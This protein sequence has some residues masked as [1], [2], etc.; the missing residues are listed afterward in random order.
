MVVLL[1]VVLALVVPQEAE[2]ETGSCPTL[3]LAKTETETTIKLQ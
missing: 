1:W 2:S 3:T